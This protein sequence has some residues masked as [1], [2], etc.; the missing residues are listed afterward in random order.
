MF[1]NTIFQ[2]LINDTASYTLQLSKQQIDTLFLSNELH[3]KM[4]LLLV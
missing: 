4:R 2:T 3:A 1:G